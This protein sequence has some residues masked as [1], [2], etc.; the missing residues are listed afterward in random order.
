MKAYDGTKFQHFSRN[1]LALINKIA[2]E[3]RLDEL[4]HV[5]DFKE[6]HEKTVILNLK[7]KLQAHKFREREK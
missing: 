3:G 7:N 6:T 5:G 4:C 2:A 1:V